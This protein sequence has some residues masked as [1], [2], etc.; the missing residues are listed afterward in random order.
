[1]RQNTGPAGHGKQDDVTVSFNGGLPRAQFPPAR[2]VPPVNEGVTVCVP[3]AVLAPA[4]SAAATGLIAKID[5]SPVFVDDSG[6][7]KRLLRIAGVLI[8]LVSIGF[9]AVV[10]VALAV[11]SVATSVGLGD[12][13]PFVVPGA[14]APPPP[15]A[16]VAPPAPKVQVVKAKPKVVAPKSNA[17]D[18]PR[19][20]Q[21]QGNQ[22]RNKNRD[23]DQDKN[24]GQNKNQGQ[25]TTEARARP[26]TRVKLG[27]RVR[28]ARRVRVGAQ[29][30]GGA[31]GPGWCGRVRVARRQASRTSRRRRSSSPTLRWLTR[32]PSS[33]RL[34][35]PPIKQPR[36]EVPLP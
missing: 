16:P 12:V 15:K 25:G 13:V 6:S 11:P 7:R 10:G 9:I 26:T 21:G 17:N 31:Q 27:S 22:G 23:Q 28:A 34:V 18:E 19:N 8:G 32:A 36:T 35:R 20:N 3:G 2:P 29:G 33:V 4:P 30:Q 1:M 24:Q 5:E 14:A